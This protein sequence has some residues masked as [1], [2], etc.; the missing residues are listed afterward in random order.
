MPV[1]EKDFRE[2]ARV[3]Y[4]DTLFF[5]FFFFFLFLVKGF[6]VFDLGVQGKTI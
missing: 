2:G 6:I 1:Q 3:L 5:F 4:K